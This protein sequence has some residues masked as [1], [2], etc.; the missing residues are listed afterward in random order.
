[1]FFLRPAIAAH[2]VDEIVAEKTIEPNLKRRIGAGEKLGEIS[3]AR[4]AFEGG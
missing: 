4:T 2:L 3:G 1:V